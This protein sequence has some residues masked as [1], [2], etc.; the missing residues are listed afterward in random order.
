MGEIIKPTTIEGGVEYERQRDGSLLWVPGTGLFPSPDVDMDWAQEVVTNPHYYKKE[1][2]GRGNS[3]DA[4]KTSDP[5]WALRINR[6]TTDTTK[7]SFFGRK[8]LTEAGLMLEGTFFVNAGLLDFCMTHP[9]QVDFYSKKDPSLIAG[10]PMYLGFCAHTGATLM[11]YE[12]GLRP[13]SMVAG[14]A[15]IASSYSKF[16][17]YRNFKANLDSVPSNII[18]QR[19]LG[20]AVIIDM[21]ATIS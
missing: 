9:T 21:Y 5:S 2:I 17:D 1:H 7:R 19:N 12:E 18:L 8:K 6:G 13:S 20:K 4:H 3:A 16:L 10:A 15:M 11:S 14:G